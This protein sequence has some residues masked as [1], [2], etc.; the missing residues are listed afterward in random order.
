MFGDVIGQKLIHSYNILSYPVSTALRDTQYS[1][2][3]TQMNYALYRV[4]SDL[5]EGFS[6]V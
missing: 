3:G 5:P 2:T 1:R 4:D 6:S